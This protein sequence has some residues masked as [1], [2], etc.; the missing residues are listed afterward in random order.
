MLLK[1]DYSY[2]DDHSDLKETHLYLNKIY[3]DIHFSDDEDVSLNEKDSCLN[4]YDCHSVVNNPIIVEKALRRHPVFN[5]PLFDYLMNEATSDD[6]K[7]FILN[8]SVLN[9]E[10]FDYLALSIV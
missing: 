7:K 3:H 8:E 10:F 2:R 6:L 9:L 1:Q 5:H 4:H